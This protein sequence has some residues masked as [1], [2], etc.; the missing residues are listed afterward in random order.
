MADLSISP[1]TQL[2]QPRLAEL[3]AAALRQRIVSGQLA[4]GDMLPKQEELLAEFRVS[5]PSIREALRILETEG[6]ITVRRGNVGGATV[7]RPKAANNAHMLALV[8]EMHNVTLGDVAAARERLEPLCASFCAE[9]KDRRKA[10]VPVLEHLQAEAE[11]Q[12]EDEVAF[13]RHSLRFHRE[14]VNLCGN[15]TMIA[16][17]SMVES[18]YTQHVDLQKRDRGAVTFSLDY[19]RA[20]LAAHQ[21]TID[22]IVA[23]DSAGVQTVMG[24][25]LRVQVSKR[26]K[27]SRLDLGQPVRVADLLG[28]GEG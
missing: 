22:C 19:R 6:L 9:R 2:K 14:L 27:A 8:L 7:H 5:K 26:T 28:G 20:T 11:R 17:A 16:L 13:T 10:V 18:V 24:D 25:H 12:V 4:D 23:G 3:V 15:Q 21:R 1:A